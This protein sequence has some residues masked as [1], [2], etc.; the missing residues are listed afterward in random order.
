MGSVITEIDEARREKNPKKKYR[1]YKKL[2]KKHRNYTILKFEYAKS[3][4]GIDNEKAEQLLTELLDTECAKSASLE[5]ARMKK[6]NGEND[7]A[8][9]MFEK[10]SEQ[11]N[12]FALCE[13]ADQALKNSEYL[14]AIKYLE[15]IIKID[16]KPEHALLKLGII[17]RKIGNDIKAREYLEQVLNT[18]ERKIALTEL[19]RVEKDECNYDKARKYLKETYEMYGD[20]NAFYRLGMLEKELGNNA[21][22]IKY[23][24]QLLKTDERRMAIKSL[25]F[26]YLKEG[27][28]D[29]AYLYFGLL[30]FDEKIENLNQKEIKLMT[31]LNSYFNYMFGKLERKDCRDYL[32]LQ[33]YSYNENEMRYHIGKHFMDDKF[34]QFNSEINID[35][36]LNIVRNNLDKKHLRKNNIADFYNIVLPYEVAEMNGIKTNTIEIVTI[37]NTNKILTIYPRLPIANEKYKMNTKTLR[38][39]N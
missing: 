32:S 34:S 20:N 21:N 6:M 9:E 31:R 37:L 25:I 7:K 38:R 15:R 3:C 10:L 4:R 23:F 39:D 14:K 8:T 24:G 13:L 2:Y 36:L 11:G 28:F 26:M 12:L 30:I 29:L 1:L 16:V 5:L 35:N 33:L 17:Y 19:S 18:P 22:A 27:N